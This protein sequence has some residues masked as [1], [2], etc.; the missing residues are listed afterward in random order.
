MFS[1]RYN[2]HDT[3]VGGGCIET[4]LRPSNTRDL[5]EEELNEV[6]SQPV[7]LNWTPHHYGEAGQQLEFGEE[8]LARIV[9]R[10]VYEKSWIHSHLDLP[11]ACGKIVHSYW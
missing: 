7:H 8:R 6:V 1:P 9:K 5:D 11:D 3:N 10:R 4:L 2:Q